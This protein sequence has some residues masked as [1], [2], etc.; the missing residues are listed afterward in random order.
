M[1]RTQQNQWPRPGWKILRQR[2]ATTQTPL[3]VREAESC[4]QLDEEAIRSSLEM[5]LLVPYLNYNKSISAEAL[6]RVTD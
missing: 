4:G 2:S 3:H 6:H 1:A 5:K